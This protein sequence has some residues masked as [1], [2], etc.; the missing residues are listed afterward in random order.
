MTKQHSEAAHDQPRPDRDKSGHPRAASRLTATEL[1]L[2]G[3]MQPAQIAATIQ[4]HPEEA[5]EILAL[6]H[7]RFGN[8]FANQVMAIV[9]GA[10]APT[11]D[12]TIAP[13]HDLDVAAIMDAVD[14]SPTP[15]LGEPRDVTTFDQSSDYREARAT[16]D[17]P[18]TTEDEPAH[19]EKAGSWVTRAIA[20][21]R[22]HADLVAMFNQATN[23]SCIDPATGELDPQKVAR[24]QVAAGAKPDGRVGES[25]V[26]AAQINVV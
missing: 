23:S 21:N 9:S 6:L 24:W 3:G 22:A 8:G 25:T 14:P 15:A 16:I 20:Y 10:P 13:P 19:A 17:S 11:A 26:I 7:D 4:A 12:V 1:L 18:V 2:R 5:A